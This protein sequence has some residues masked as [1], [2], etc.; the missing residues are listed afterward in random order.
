MATATTN[1]FSRIPGTDHPSLDGQLYIQ[2]GFDIVRQGLAKAGWTNLTANDH[3]ELRNRTYAHTAY[4]YS[5][6]ERGGP[7]ATYLVT[8]NGR[9]NFHMWLNTSVERINRIGGHAVSLDV[10]PTNNG[11]HLGTVPLTPIT[12]RVIISAGAFGT[13]KLLFR[14]GIGPVDQ[15]TI[16]QSS[17]DGPKMIN[18]SYWINNTA[19][20]YNLDDHLN[21]DCVISHPNI[22]YYDWVAAWDTPI[23]ADASNYLTKRIG[24]LAQAAPNSK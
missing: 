19:V 7:M 6:G 13:P 9:S 11:G 18:S 21:T 17:T 22:S 1:V 3:P 5:H 23:A 10:I 16:V 15:L 8:A 14:S 20:G 24:P 12:G 2:S 4:M